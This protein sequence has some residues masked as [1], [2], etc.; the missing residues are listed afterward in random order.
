MAIIHWAK[1]L[2]ECG[3]VVRG[4]GG[5]K[6]AMEN[7]RFFSKKPPSEPSVLRVMFQIAAISLHTKNAVMAVVWHEDYTILNM[8]GT[9]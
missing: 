8:C 2:S 9:L 3:E 7:H 6:S 4:E 5:A 1:W